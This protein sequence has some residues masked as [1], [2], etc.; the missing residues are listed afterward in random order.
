MLL[1]TWKMS[2]CAI[3]TTA[4]VIAITAPVC[5][6]IVRAPAIVV[7]GMGTNGNL[8]RSKNKKSVAVRN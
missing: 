2:A 8:A 3:V 4:L 6:T 1:I 7:R 5:V